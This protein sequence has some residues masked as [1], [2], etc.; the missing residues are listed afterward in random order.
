MTSLANRKFTHPAFSG[1]DENTAK[2]AVPVFT[3]SENFNT[4][5]ALQFKNLEIAVVSISRN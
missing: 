5:L 1:V 4:R 3:V 2:R